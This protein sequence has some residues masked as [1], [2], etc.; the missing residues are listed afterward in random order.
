MILVSSVCRKLPLLER[1][2]RGTHERPFLQAFSRCTYTREGP[3]SHPLVWRSTGRGGRSTTRA[4]EIFFFSFSRSM[5]MPSLTR[6]RFSGGPSP[7]SARFS[8]LETKL[9][10]LSFLCP[11][12]F[13]WSPCRR[14]RFFSLVRGVSSANCV[15]SILGVC[16]GG[17]STSFKINSLRFCFFSSLLSDRSLLSFLCGDRL[18]RVVETHLSEIANEKKASLSFSLSVP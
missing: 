14:S 4:E 15:S 11:P 12:Y 5:R 17:N 3:D 8:F 6:P 13:C 18:L 7:N 1:K 9:F 10:S 2:R 16:T